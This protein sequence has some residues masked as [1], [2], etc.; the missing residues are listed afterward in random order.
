MNERSWKTAGVLC[1][2]S[3]ITL[4]F[5][6]R[7]TTGFLLGA[8]LAVWLYKRNETYW[9]EVVDTR[10]AGRR[11]G[12]FHFLVNYAIMAGAMI[13]AVRL[14]QAFNVFAVAVGLTIIKLAVI[15]DNFLPYRKGE[16]NA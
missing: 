5:N 2:L 10:S 13:L 4:F 8:V 12:F 9:N 7:I 1:V 14:P 6:W 15:I 16:Q 3:L 11:T